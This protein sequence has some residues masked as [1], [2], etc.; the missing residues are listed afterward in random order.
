[1]RLAGKVAIVTGS[2]QGIG[3]AMVVRMAEEGA[4]VVVTG[5]DPEKIQ[6]VVD[7][8]RVQG[9]TAMGRSADVRMRPDVRELVNAARKEFGQVDILVNNAIARRRSRSFLD[10]TDE[11][12]DV[13]LATGLKGT[14]NCIQAVAPH[15]ME[16]RYGKIINVSSTSGMGGSS[17]PNECN[18]NYAAT[19]AGIIQLTKTFAREF[20]PYGINVN[21][22]SP[23]SIRTADSFTKRSPEAAAKHA[24]EREKLAV[25]GRVGKPEEI[26]DL[27]VFLASD[28]SSFITAQNIVADGGRTDYML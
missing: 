8:I 4:A 2:G 3:K 1:M 17:G 15:M 21:C 26:A 19:K 16:R 27:T 6:N 28:E 11:D 9:G 7:E 13:V 22:V 25:L 12:W 5:R 18:A 20:G 23:G 14:F 10:M 24:A